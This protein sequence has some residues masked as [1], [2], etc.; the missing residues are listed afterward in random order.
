MGAKESSVATIIPESAIEK[1]PDIRVIELIDPIP[2][3]ISAVLWAKHRFRSAAAR[4]FA[5]L[6]RDRFLSKLVLR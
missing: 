6:V 3:R 4:T 2:V 1:N 5:Q